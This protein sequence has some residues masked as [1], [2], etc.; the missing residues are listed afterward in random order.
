[1]TRTGLGEISSQQVVGWCSI[2][3][4]CCLLVCFC[5]NVIICGKKFYLFSFV[6]TFVTT[7]VTSFSF[8][9]QVLSATGHVLGERKLRVGRGRVELSGMAVRVVSGLSLQIAKHRYLPGALTATAVLDDKLFA[10]QQVS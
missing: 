2:H 3:F 1:M 5:C 6:T 9:V 7:F 4:S 10:R 8:A